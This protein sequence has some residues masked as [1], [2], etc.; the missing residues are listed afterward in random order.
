MVFNPLSG[1]THL[2]DIV[3]GQ[4]LKLIM[5]GSSSVGELRPGTATFLEVDDDNHL[6]GTIS[7]IL[8]RLEEAGLIEPVR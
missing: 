2:L 5:S 3:T 8:I 6:A 7:D 4:I 1:Q